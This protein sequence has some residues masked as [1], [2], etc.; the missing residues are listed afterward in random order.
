MEQKWPNFCCEGYDFIALEYD[1][2]GYGSGICLNPNCPHGDIEQG[3]QLDWCQE[4][5]EEE[6]IEEMIH[7]FITRRGG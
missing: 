7:Q 5:G 3:L 4:E 6:I 1:S 2:T